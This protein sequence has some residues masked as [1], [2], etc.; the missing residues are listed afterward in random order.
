MPSADEP[1]SIGYILED[2]SELVQYGPLYDGQGQLRIRK[3]E[4]GQAALPANFL[5]YDIPPGAS[6]GVHVHETGSPLGAYEEFYFI[7]SGRGEMQINGERI[8]VKPGDH[9][10]VPLGASRGIENT[11][12]A[13]LRVLLTYILRG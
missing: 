9:V 8:P 1:S 13:D 2:T 12:S 6:E 10:F 5:L 7:V 4:F 3:F 11:S